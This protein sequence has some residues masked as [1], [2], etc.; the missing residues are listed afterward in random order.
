MFNR[1]RYTKKYYQKHKEYFKVKYAEWVKQMPDKSKN[2]I[3][4]Y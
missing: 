2:K 3:L 1:Q 4:L